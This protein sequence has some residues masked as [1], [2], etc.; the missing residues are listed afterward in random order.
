MIIGNQV[1]EEEVKDFEMNNSDPNIG[2]YFDQIK[3]D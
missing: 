2:S 1:V 3:D